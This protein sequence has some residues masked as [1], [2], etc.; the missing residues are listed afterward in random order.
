MRDW[1]ELPPDVL[2]LVFAELGAV[3]VLLGA[4]LVCRSW[5]HAAKHLPHLWRRVDMARHE[6]VMGR[7]FLCAMAKV[8][9]DRSDGQLEVFEGRYFVDDEL[10]DYIGESSMR[11]TGYGG[12]GNNGALTTWGLRGS[13]A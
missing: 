13:V 5:L 11:P 6:V 9:V 4:G 1:S 3:E 12:V 8:A 7:G 10:L 2:S